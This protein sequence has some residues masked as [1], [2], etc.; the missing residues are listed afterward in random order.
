MF[1]QF[2]KEAG[3]AKHDGELSTPAASGIAT[4]IKN[5]ATF[6]EPGPGPHELA[7]WQAFA[8]EFFNGSGA[9]VNMTAT[10]HLALS[11]IAQAFHDR[12]RGVFTNRLV[13]NLTFWRTW[14][15]KN[16]VALYHPY[17]SYAPF[18]R[19]FGVESFQHEMKIVELVQDVMSLRKDFQGFQNEL[20][21]LLNGA[22]PTSIEIKSWTDRKMVLNV[23]AY[24]DWFW[25]RWTSVHVDVR[26]PTSF[27]TSGVYGSTSIDL[28]PTEAGPGERKVEALVIQSTSDFRYDP[29]KTYVVRVRVWWFELGFSWFSEISSFP[30]PNNKMME[31]S[32][33]R[34]PV[35]GDPMIKI[36]GMDP[37]Y[38]TG[39]RP[40]IQGKQYHV[41]VTCWDESDLYPADTRIEGVFYTALGT[42]TKV[43]QLPYS[44]QKDST[45]ERI[46]GRDQFKYTLAAVLDTEVSSNIPS[47][48]WAYM[49]IRARITDNGKYI[50]S[51]SRHAATK[52]REKA[53]IN[54]K[55]F[56]VTSIETLYEWATPSSASPYDYHL[57]PGERGGFELELFNPTNFPFLV[58][59]IGFSITSHDAPGPDE[60][61]VEELI[62]FFV[63]PVHARPIYVDSDAFKDWV[64]GKI[65]QV[66]SYTLWVR[67]NDAFTFM[68]SIDVDNPE[69][70]TTRISDQRSIIDIPYRDGDHKP[71]ASRLQITLVNNARV[72]MNINPELVFSFGHMSGK[73][74][75]VEKIGIWQNNIVS[76]EKTPV[77]I[78][79]NGFSVHFSTGVL[80]PLG[81]ESSLD[82]EFTMRDCTIF[83]PPLAELLDVAS[84]FLDLA[85]VMVCIE[86]ALEL[87]ENNDGWTDGLGLLLFLISLIEASYASYSENHD[88][89]NK[90]RLT[91]PSITYTFQ[92]GDNTFQGEISSHNRVIRTRATSEQELLLASFIFNKW[93]V[94]G[95]NLGSVL[96]SAAPYVAFAF[97]L[98]AFTANRIAYGISINMNG[99]DPPIPITTRVDRDYPYIEV[100][101]GMTDPDQIARFLQVQDLQ[102]DQWAMNET[103]SRATG[104]QLAASQEE[105]EET[106]LFYLEMEELHKLDY[107]FFSDRYFS[108]NVDV[109]VSEVD[110]AASLVQ[111]VQ[112][113]NIFSDYELHERLD[114]VVENRITT[115][116][117]NNIIGVGIDEVT[118]DT[119]QPHLNE[120]DI[121]ATQVSFDSIE[122]HLD[123]L[124]RSFRT[125]NFQASLEQI[126]RNQR[127]VQDIIDLRQERGVAIVEPITEEDL[128][129]FEPKKQE[130][131]DLLLD[132]SYHDV[133]PKVM[134]LINDV[135]T[136][137]LDRNNPD[138]TRVMSIIDFCTS[139]LDVAF[140]EM[141]DYSELPLIIDGNDA[142]AAASN[143]GDGVSTPFVI[144]GVYIDVTRKDGRVNCVEIRNT[145]APFIIKNSA[146]R[147]TWTL[148]S[149]GSGI[150]LENVTNAIITGNTFLGSAFLAIHVNESCNSITIQENVVFGFAL[151]GILSSGRDVTIR[152]NKIYNTDLKAWK[153]GISLHHATG[154]VLHDNRLYFCGFGAGAMELVHADSHVIS[155]SNL[156][157]GRPVH[158]LVRASQETIDAILFT[159][160]DA[161][162]LYSQVFLIDC[163]D[164]V[165]DGLSFRGLIT[166]GLVIAFSRNVI[167]QDTLFE[168]GIYNGLII[169]ESVDC[170]VRDNWFVSNE[171]GLFISGHET[172][173]SVI[174]ERNTF[175]D[176]IEGIHLEATRQV[177]VRENTIRFMVRA[178]IDIRDGCDDILIFSNMF[179]DSQAGVNIRG[180]EATITR[181]EFV[182]LIYGTNME[183]GSSLVV[184]NN[185]FR[186]NA[187]HVYWFDAEV[188]VTFDNGVIGNR[189][190]D[191]Q[192]KY[193]CAHVAGWGIEYRVAVWDTPYEVGE[194]HF[195]TF[196][197]VVHA[198][199]DSFFLSGDA[200]VDVFFAGQSGRDGLTPETAYLLEARLFTPGPGGI[201]IRFES[202]TRHVSIKHCH[203]EGNPE[204]LGHVG[205]HL[206]MT[207]NIKIAG[208]VIENVNTGIVGAMGGNIVVDESVFRNPPRAGKGILV[209]L[210]DPFTFTG[211][212]ISGFDVGM[213]LKR[214]NNHLISDNVI[215]DCTTGIVDRL[216]NKV[217]TNNVIYWC[218]VAM[219]FHD[220][221][222]NLIAS[223]IIAVN[224]AGIIATNASNIVVVDNVF[225][226]N[227]GYAVMLDGTSWNNSV[228][229]NVFWENNEGGVQS[230]D[231]SGANEW[232]GNYWSDFDDR[233]PGAGNDGFCWTT[234][235]EIDGGAGA[236]DARPI[237]FAPVD[238]PVIEMLAGLH[239]GLLELASIIDTIPNPG[240]RT[241]CRVHVEHAMSHVNELIA[242]YHR[243]GTINQDAIQGIRQKLHVIDTVAKSGPVAVVRASIDAMLDAVEGWVVEGMDA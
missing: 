133:Q 236:V 107:L 36:D 91:I 122:N 49:D 5:P 61:R 76:G 213:D 160:T 99:F 149:G 16:I 237:M 15:W 77:P 224:G 66:G 154:N 6:P 1:I 227:T 171:N 129:V 175:L 221:D 117:R 60:W 40:F 81:G 196:P 105:N 39:A 46:D 134:G 67:V 94:V 159:R 164:I 200:A 222:N 53:V 12:E 41:R 86:V 243:E 85:G 38:T 48:D 26:D 232:S 155:P 172:T 102:Y 13:Y 143:D 106:R 88:L 238:D 33:T 27:L 151:A 241:A 234:G 235:Y 140:R 83:K 173:S 103:S 220:A 101:E 90:Y 230:F 115:E 30:V 225:G 216:C 111:A 23:S 197:I 186:D 51:G 25:T 188:E 191:Y 29:S 162:H 32:D 166:S 139:A 97:S 78:T 70:P 137:M 206:Y 184:F 163:D 142:L 92:G 190:G 54:Y 135:F 141:K 113:E 240:R 9:L 56:T 73:D 179:A 136:L 138:D 124:R 57:Y 199:S 189:W 14:T 69:Q 215:F 104:A 126:N 34:A 59:S 119:I 130:I 202:T 47:G 43:V 35:V 145:D 147:N 207:S 98:A 20:S 174:V 180:S 45:T 10:Q 170:V 185:T 121:P 205:I 89:E 177:Q 193:P 144:S 132:G 161:H 18:S 187:N 158:Y 198:P 79:G 96:S 68:F 125:W 194:G 62:D 114:S 8:L 108:S 50:A 24:L 152:G 128:L 42:L 22:R 168:D 19:M 131:Q 208:S 110:M 74:T 109:V 228:S 11:R 80:S 55:D 64:A 178:G 4:E 146:F 156:V 157:N 233:Y 127:F 75:S 82:I 211:N 2:D 65:P 31:Y 209:E 118:I 150:V 192:D 195:D 95:L 100:P 153:S 17:D 169:G 229:D 204:E 210:L 218:D 181:N 226:E 37:H 231:G 58:S 28:T 223:N 120:Y 72:P 212:M 148:F 219:E 242:T 123:G 217:F 165:L 63:D 201:G 203:V 44:I 239:A 167:V 176:G 182:H 3:V 71:G 214:G 93:V 116:I 7:F 52:I 183:F 21:L 112:D 84:V 87:I